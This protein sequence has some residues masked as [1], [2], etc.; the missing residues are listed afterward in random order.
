MSLTKLFALIE[1][2]SVPGLA[3]LKWTIILCKRGYTSDS[4][5]ETQASDL[6]RSINVGDSK[7]RSVINA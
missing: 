5:T 4:H 2:V 6:P 3:R 1:A 7:G